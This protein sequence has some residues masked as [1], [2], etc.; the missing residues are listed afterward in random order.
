MTTTH[1]N[2]TEEPHPMTTQGQAAHT[3][4]PEG[5]TTLFVPETYSMLHFGAP[6]TDAERAAFAELDQF[7]RDRHTESGAKK[8]QAAEGF[9][10]A[11]VKCERLWNA[12]RFWGAA[13]PLLEHAAGELGAGG[14]EAAETAKLMAM[15]ALPALCRR[16]GIEVKF[17]GRPETDGRTIWLG[18]VDF[19]HPAA[20]VYLF[21]H[22]VHE[23]C[24]VV[25]TDFGSLNERFNQND[26]RDP[27]VEALTNLF[28]DVRVDALGMEEC[29]GYRFWREALFS[30]LCASGRSAFNVGATTPAPML[31][32]G[33]LLAECEITTLGLKLPEGVFERVDKEARRRLGCGLVDEALRFVKS[34]MPLKDTL[35]ARSLAVDCVEM[36]ADRYGLAV[37]ELA[38][39]EQ[40][41]EKLRAKNPKPGAS[42]ARSSGC[43][44][45]QV[46]L[47]DSDD[48]FAPL[49]EVPEAPASQETRQDDP[50]PRG[51]N[52]SADAEKPES[53][54]EG[55]SPT[56]AELRREVEVLK[57]LVDPAAWETPSE[58]DL[59]A[60]A[61]KSTSLKKSEAAKRV[62]KPVLKTESGIDMLA[63]S[64][65]GTESTDYFDPCEVEQAW[66]RALRRSEEIAERSARRERLKAAAAEAEARKCGSTDG[67]EDSARAFLGSPSSDEIKHARKAFDIVW[68]M[69]S[70]LGMR[71]AEALRRRVPAMEGGSSS[72]WDVDP[73][74][75]RKSVV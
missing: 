12:R 6:E 43:T 47:F 36:L 55:K 48:L 3:N 23:R 29:R 18:P 20:P 70:C 63:E 53:A 60:Q 62:K 52:T 9:R 1:S 59:L 8:R 67:F 2:H 31:F 58:E 65:A 45:K 21:G 71:F 44:P 33:R 37:V 32:F 73:D 61:G 27:R 15:L 24:H 69:T 39:E 54:G 64:L 30:V 13:K 49:D 4:A 38:L 40:R 16:D 28:E 10:K 75:D 56:L 14:P 26:R 41:L 74:L 25:H 17:K 68:P 42:I 19:T 72:G 50:A 46:S 35:A 22:G 57:V 34:R 11:L 66:R 51:M 7:E 5:P